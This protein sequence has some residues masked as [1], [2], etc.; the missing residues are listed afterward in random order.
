MPS[1]HNPNNVSIGGTS[2]T[3]VLA[4]EWQEQR[5]QIV[6]PLADGETYHTIAEHGSAVIGGRILLR[7]PSQAAIAANKTGT[8]AATLAGIGGG[9]DQTLSMTGVSTGGAT[10][11]VRHGRSAACEV[12]FVA[13]SSNGTTS[14]VSLT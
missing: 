3:D 13:A 1:V 5:E 11:L 14:P 10:N 7:N 8:L 4:I 9:A 2:L 12:P 6:G